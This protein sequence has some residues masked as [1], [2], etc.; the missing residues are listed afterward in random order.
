MPGLDNVPL[1]NT[2]RGLAELYDTSQP[3]IFQCFV[4]PS[5]IAAPPGSIDP[6]VGVYPPIMCGSSAFDDALRIL[7]EDPTTFSSNPTPEELFAA[8]SV[9]APPQPHAIDPPPSVSTDPPQDFNFDEY[10]QDFGAFDV[11]V[12]LSFPQNN[13]ETPSA[14]WECCEPDALI[15]CYHTVT[16]FDGTNAPSTTKAALCATARRC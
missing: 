9:L 15:L 11:T 6:G 16:R 2:V 13:P 4:N 14:H 10:L 1:Q 5:L 12:T 3:G 8:L 7:G